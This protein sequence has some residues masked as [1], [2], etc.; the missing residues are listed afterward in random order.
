MQ[1]LWEQNKTANST[2][3]DTGILGWHLPPDTSCLSSGTVETK[4]E[5]QK[6]VGFK[7]YTSTYTEEVG[8]CSVRAQVYGDP[9]LCFEQDTGSSL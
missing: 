3:W 7:T 6:L 1:W 4:K 8:A 9:A 2:A 5:K